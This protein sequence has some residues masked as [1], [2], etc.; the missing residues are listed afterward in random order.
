VNLEA[1]ITLAIYAALLALALTS[2][3]GLIF[4]LAW[5]GVGAWFVAKT[6]SRGVFADV[7]LLARWPLYVVLGR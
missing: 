2:L 4:T 3:P 1:I 6:R 7:S 5:L